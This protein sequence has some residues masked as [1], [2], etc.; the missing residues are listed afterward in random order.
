MDT[1]FY[2]AAIIGPAFPGSPG[3]KG[4]TGLPGIAGLPGGPGTDGFPGRNGDKGNFNQAV[5]LNLLLEYY[6]SLIG[7]QIASLSQSKPTESND[8]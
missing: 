4:T 6:A 5:A 7:T 3:S 2:P 8:F 1:I